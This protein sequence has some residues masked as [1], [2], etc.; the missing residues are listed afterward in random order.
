VFTACFPRCRLLGNAHEFVLSRQVQTFY[1][2]SAK[3]IDSF[4][5]ALGSHQE[6]PVTE[7]KNSFLLIRLRL[8]PPVYNIS[9]LLYNSF[10]PSS[11][12]KQHYPTAGS[13]TILVDFWRTPGELQAPWGL[14]VD[15]RWTL[16]DSWR[17]HLDSQV[18]SS[19]TPLGVL[20]ECRAD[21][22]PDLHPN[23]VASGVK[24][25]LQSILN[26]AQMSLV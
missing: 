20:L 5:P 6:L 2:A 25:S 18:D 26:C 13:M 3:G 4:R 12:I 11:D 9:T 24:C 1:L 16:L 23:S 8:R 22:A 21:S 10:T 17:T 14:Q 15:S 7:E 19:R